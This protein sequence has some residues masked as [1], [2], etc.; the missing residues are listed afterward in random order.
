MIYTI[1]IMADEAVGVG[2]WMVKVVLVTVLLPPKLSTAT[3]LFDWVE[4]NIN[5]PA[6]V[7]VARGQLTSE[8]PRYAVVPLDVGEVLTPTVTPPAV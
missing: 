4:L 5:A 1:R 6:A 8:K 2:N 3:D 7:N